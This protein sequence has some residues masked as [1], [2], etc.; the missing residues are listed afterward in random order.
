[1][2]VQKDDTAGDSTTQSR[3]DDAVPLEMGRVVRRTAIIGGIALLAILVGFASLWAYDRWAEKKQEAFR[4]SCEAAVAAQ[5]WDELLQTATAWRDWDPDNDDSLM[6]IA[7]A[8]VDLERLD[9]AVETLGRVED[10]YKGALEALAFRA[11]IQYSALNRPFDAEGTW[12]RMVKI[13]PNANLPR[14][15]LIY[16]YAMTLQRN[17][18]E[19]QIREAVML[20]CE[21]PEAYSYIL[22]KNV[23]NFSDGLAKTT[24]WLLNYPDDET[25]QVAQAV[26]AAR[27]D[28]EGKIAT[29]GFRTVM[30]G[31]LDLVERRLKQYPSNLEL[32]AVKIDQAIF[33]GDAREVTELLA[34]A[35][36]SAENDS[37][38]WRIR[39]W[40]ML[41]RGRY[42]EAVE[43]FE[44]AIDIN[45]F[46]WQARWLLAD[47]LRKLN[48]TEEAD[49]ASALALTGKELQQRIFEKP[50]A[51][52][53]DEELA[54][55]ILQYARDLEATLFAESLARRLNLTP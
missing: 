38:F 46:D 26:Y 21:P 15:R 14:Q 41:D 10:D 49:R 31:S 39:G 34:Q 27:Q 6:F 22:L 3:P 51:R 19:Q 13:A 44:A 16:F 4:T 47:A 36:P 25:L 24:R 29:F 42:E 9:E 8:L 52:D 17:A 28:S 32:L 48:R 20:E 35:N 11:E 45:V 23:L 33:E 40:L 37:R 2:T 50:S 53:L 5:D 55:D 12:R 30:P 1:M 18:M 7:Q 54:A 43:A